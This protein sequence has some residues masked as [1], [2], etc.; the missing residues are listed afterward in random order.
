MT[1]AG[2]TAQ[3]RN[4]LTA[5]FSSLHFRLTPL[6]FHSL[7]GRLQQLPGCFQRNPLALQQSP[8]GFQHLPGALQRSPIAFQQ[9]PVSF[10]GNPGALQQ[11]P[12]AFQQNPGTLQRNPG[13]LQQN[14]LGRGGLLMLLHRNDLRTTTPIFSGKDSDLWLRN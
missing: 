12:G 8:G 4:G 5:G 6:A 7:P 1:N 13:A 2:C 10:H 14:P 3:R 9:N 11:Y